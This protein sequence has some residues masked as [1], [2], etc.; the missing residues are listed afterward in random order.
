[1]N[2]CKK[3]TNKT[4]CSAT[5]YGYNGSWGTSGGY[6]NTSLGIINPATATATSI[7]TFS[8]D[9]Y[10]NQA[11]YNTSDHCYYMFKTGGGSQT[12]YKI[13]LSG[14]VTS[15]SNASGTS[16][17]YDGLVYSAA[18]NKL[19]GIKVVPGSSAIV[20]ISISGSLFTESIVASTIGTHYWASP[21]TCS[22]NNATG[23]IFYALRNV[24]VNSWY[25]EKYHP[26]ASSATLIDSGTNAGILGL[27]FNKNDNMLYAMQEGAAPQKMIKIDPVSGTVTSLATL[28][29]VVNNEFYSSVIDACSNRYIVTSSIDTASGTFSQ[30][31]MSGAVLQHDTVNTIYQGLEVAY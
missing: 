31:D 28:G 22:I 5:V 12:L 18:A 26:G 16:I 14:A 13:S 1:M 19:Y 24:T 11:T 8:S 23:D 6:L 25:I 9:V 30:L 17:R 10:S 20:E 29:F 3:N 7:C 21:A 15:Y 4:T 27:R 2:S